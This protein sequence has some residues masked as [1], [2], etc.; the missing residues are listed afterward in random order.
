MAVQ[1]V[2]VVMNQAAKNKMSNAEEHL[3]KSDRFVLVLL[4][5]EAR[6]LV[7]WLA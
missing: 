5:M 4:P 7:V 1:A 3:E 6:K 2:L